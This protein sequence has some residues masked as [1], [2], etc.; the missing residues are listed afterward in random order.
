MK[1]EHVFSDGV[2][3]PRLRRGTI[4]VYLQSVLQN[5]LTW[6]YRSRGVQTSPRYRSTSVPW[7]KSAIPK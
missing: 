2:L 6:D 4:L 3:T 5:G 1:G 7:P